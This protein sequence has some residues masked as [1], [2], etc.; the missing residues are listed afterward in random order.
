MRQVIIL[1]FFFL[2]A[3][4]GFGQI[5]FFKI[6]TDNGYDYGQ[7]IVQLADSSYLV[8]GSSSSYADNPS[9][10]F[11]MK[12]DSLGTFQWSKNFG[13][14]ESDWGRRVLSWNDTVFY[15]AGYSNSLGSGSYNFYLVKTD[16]YGNQLSERHYNHPGW[17]KLNDAL[18]TADSTLYMVG[19]TTGT[20]NGDRNV[21]IVKTDHNGDTLWTRNF[22]SSGEDAANS[23]RQY[24]DTTFFVV[25]EMYNAD[26]TLT[27]G[28]I[29]KI[30]ANGDTAWVKQ[31]GLD[32]NYSL[33]DCF[34]DGTLLNAVGVRVFPE[35]G[36]DDEYR[37]KSDI[38]GADLNEI[39]D[40]VLG[41]VSLDHLCKYGI[42]NKILI[43]TSFKNV[44][45]VAGTYDSGVTRYL[46]DFTFDFGF[47][48]VMS[49]MQDF[50]G[51]LISTSDGGVI[52]TGYMEGGML[53]GSS[54][55]VL[56]VGPNDDY[57]S[58]NWSDFSSIAIESLVSIDEIQIEELT[59]FKMYP[60][61]A[62]NLVSIFTGTNEL[63]EIDIVDVYGKTLWKESIVNNAQFDVSSWN[64]AVYFIR[65]SKNKQLLKTSKLVV[66]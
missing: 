64:S 31:Y 29:I 5:K 53:G 46:S 55:F 21:Y 32:G 15:I 14:S 8:T 58:I 36:E 48:N 44:F 54:V 34:F 10:V 62:S 63:I 45:S 18:I 33:N 13:G 27:K 24:N 2:Q 38:N 16:E 4:V 35:D 6:F 43:A 42:N 57:P 28:A 11:L 23:I 19:E 17:E 1:L 50:T 20:A 41:D 59:D 66:H 39:S 37:L 22:G 49:G 9:Q 52:F 61:P 56:K 26:S 7:G 51:N 3:F 12:L 60:N 40:H 65:I 30:Y 25:G 47:V